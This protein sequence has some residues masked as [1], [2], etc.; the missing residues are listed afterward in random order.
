MPDYYFYDR[1]V[2]YTLFVPEPPEILILT[3]AVKTAESRFKELAV[4]PMNNTGTFIMS[5]GS[6]N[7]GRKMAMCLAGKDCWSC[8]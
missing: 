6:F 3:G 4:F 8:V 1:V 7:H 2:L 5:V